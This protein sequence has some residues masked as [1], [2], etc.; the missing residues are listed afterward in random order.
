[1]KKLGLY[2]IA[3]ILLFSFGC[4]SSNAFSER[5]MNE[6]GAALIKLSSSVE[7][8]VYYK[9]IVCDGL[10]DD[11]LL[12][13]STKHDPSLLE[14]FNDYKLR[15]KIQNKHA[16]VLVCSGDGANAL[17][18]DAGCTARMELHRWKDQPLSPCE[19]SL[20][21]NKVCEKPE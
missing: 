17:L 4:T 3:L 16:A 8:A 15:V 7:S 10:S 21:L 9:G 12:S 11:Q 13:L 19:F 2:L 20:D 5:D 1:M 14:P 6:L 18:E